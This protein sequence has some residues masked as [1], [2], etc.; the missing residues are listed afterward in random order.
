MSKHDH[1]RFYIIR[2]VILNAGQQ[3]GFQLLWVR[4][5]IQI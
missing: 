3:I 4:Q 2:T 5:I 1:H